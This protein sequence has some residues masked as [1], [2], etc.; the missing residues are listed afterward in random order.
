MLLNILFLS[1]KFLYISQKKLCD[2]VIPGLRDFSFSPSS[3]FIMI[4]NSRNAKLKYALKGHSWS[5]KM[6]K[7]HKTKYDLR[8]H[9]RTHKAFLFLV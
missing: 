2:F 9:G 4:K 3:T 6:S 1:N 5:H 8:D 7:I